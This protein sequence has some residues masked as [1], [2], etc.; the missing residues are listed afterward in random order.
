MQLSSKGA[1][2]MRPCIS[3]PMPAMPCLHARRRSFPA[4]RAKRAPVIAYDTVHAH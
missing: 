3:F 4:Q 1:E 2:G